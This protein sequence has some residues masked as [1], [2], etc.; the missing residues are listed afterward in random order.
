VQPGRLSTASVRIEVVDGQITITGRGS[1][2]HLTVPG[3]G[4]VLAD[5]G[6]F[7]SSLEGLLSIAGLHMPAGSEFCAALSA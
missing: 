4:L 7:V 1:Q 5:A 3:A 2:R 6:R